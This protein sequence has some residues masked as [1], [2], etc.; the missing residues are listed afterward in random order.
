MNC[1]IAN[2]SSFLPDS[3][4]DIFVFAS[5]SRNIVLVDGLIKW[6]AENFMMLSKCGKSCRILGNDLLKI[7]SHPNII[8]ECSLILDFLSNWVKYLHSEEEKKIL[9]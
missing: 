6:M 8:K 7:W 5:R 2:F 1:L 4:L 9:P 3:I